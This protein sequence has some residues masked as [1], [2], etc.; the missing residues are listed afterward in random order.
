MCSSDLSRVDWTGIQITALGTYSKGRLVIT[1]NA[2]INFD[3]CTFTDMNTFG[4]L[5]NSTILATTFR[6][7]GI[8]TQSGGSTFT[9]CKFDKASGVKAIIVDTV[10]NITN[11]EFISSGTGYAMEGFSTAGSYS[12]VGLKFSGYAAQGGTAAD[13]AIHV[14]ATTG[15]VEIT[16]SGGGD[17]PSYNSDGAT[18]TFPS[19]VPMTVTIV[20]K[21]N[22]LINGVQVAIY[23]T[24]TG[25][26][27]M[28]EDTGP[29]NA[30]GVATQAYTGSL[31]RNIYLRARKSSTGA[32]KYIAASTT[33]QIVTGTGYSVQITIYEDPN[34]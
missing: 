1:D 8:V 10:A 28:N 34:A 33:G 7:C 31:P 20:D 19:S 17:T 2:D 18:V 23:A 6:R 29:P 30:N 15:A 32:T 22:A 9:S 24:D 14:L 12:F 27:L 26:E 4:F 13:R 25:T 11:T 16:I 21:T 5:A 3:T